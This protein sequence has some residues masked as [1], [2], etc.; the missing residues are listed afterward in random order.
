M[1]LG[2]DTLM[3]GK[4]PCGR[5]PDGT[6]GTHGSYESGPI[7][8]ISRKSPICEAAAARSMTDWC[9]IN[10]RHHAPTRR[11]APLRA[12][13]LV[14]MIQADLGPTLKQLAVGL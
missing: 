10:R 9:V 4:A 7:S 12:Q 13:Y 1:R 8:R 6:Y 3:G 11:Y 14:Q 5:L 2:G